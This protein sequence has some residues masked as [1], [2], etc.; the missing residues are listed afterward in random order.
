M[1][2]SSLISLDFLGSLLM[3]ILHFFSSLILFR[4]L[5]FTS[6]LRSLSPLSFYLYSWNSYVYFYSLCLF[7]HV[8]L[9]A[10][11][12]QTRDGAHNHVF[13]LNAADLRRAGEASCDTMS[14]GD[15]GSQF[16]V[17]KSAACRG[18]KEPP[19]GLHLGENLP[20]ESRKP[21][22]HALVFNWLTEPPWRADA[23]ALGRFGGGA[24]DG[25]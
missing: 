3:F 5:R 18:T 20:L 15:G 10:A 22:R 1:F 21:P 24:G 13:V 8:L 16:R 14:R 7:L 9:F 6:S 17:A 11:G 23:A 19:S 25:T 12:L 2:V 4:V